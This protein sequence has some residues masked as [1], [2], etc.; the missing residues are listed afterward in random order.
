MKIFLSYAHEDR[1]IAERI[2]LALRANHH[3]VF[4]DRTGLEG[5]GEYNAELRKQIE[6]CHCF[7]FLISPDS[8]DGGRGGGIRTDA[9]VTLCD[10][11]MTKNSSTDDRDLRAVGS[12]GSSLP[13]A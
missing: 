6:R 5:G 10:V 9:D 11:V 1:D 12:S 13:M 7:V 4:V 2:A 3:D 8:I